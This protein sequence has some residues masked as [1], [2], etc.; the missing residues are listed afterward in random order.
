MHV[1]NKFFTVRVVRLSNRLPRETVE[2][3]SLEM[4]KVRLNG[5]LKQSDLAVDIPV[6]C[7]VVG[8]GGL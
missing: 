4:L 3:P 5:A 8:L 7:G 1:L 2:A 6:H